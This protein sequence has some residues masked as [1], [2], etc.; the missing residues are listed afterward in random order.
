M[1]LAIPGASRQGATHFDLIHGDCIAGM[2]SLEAGTVE[3]AVTSPPYNLGVRYSTYEDARKWTDYLDWS[4][5]WAAGVKRVLRD[6][7]AL[8]LNVGGSPSQPMLPHLL[9][10]KFSELFRL[11]NTFHWIKSITVNPPDG[12]EISAGHFKPIQSGRFV[13][14]CHEYIFHFTKTGTVP[15]HR[16]AEGVGVAYADKSN[17]ARWKHTRGTT[18]D[19]DGATEAAAGPGLDRR[20]RGNTWFIPYE[21]I[22][23]RDRDR[24]HPAT[25]PAAL[26]RRCLQLHGVS[27]ERAS[28]AVIL[29]PFLGIGNSALAARECGAGRFLGFEIDAGYLAIA[30]ERLRAVGA[31]V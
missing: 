11:Q 28:G 29:D 15:I 8:F 7:G 4:L 9:A 24:P 25:F 30:R 20:C 16:R 10:L 31:S 23:S 21:T 6:D 12:R 13:N 26:A 14:D 1:S 27:G 2:E 5:R 22:Q 18:G 19:G 3:V 17:I